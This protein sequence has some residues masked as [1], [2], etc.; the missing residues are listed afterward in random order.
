MKKAILYVRVSTDEQASHG[1]SLRDQEQRLIAYANIQGI[2]IK[3]IFREDHS[4]KN[5]NR[6]EFNKL[7]EF[8]KANKRNIDLLLFIKW[9]R[10]S[11]NATEAYEV[12]K[13]F[14]Q[15]SIEPQAIEQPLD[16]EIPE[17]KLMLALYL[18]APEVENDRR[19]M[20]TINGI[21][22]AKKEGRW[23]CGSPKGYS[24][25]RDEYNKPIIVPNDD[26]V[27]IKEA[28]EE[29]AK[30]LKP[31]DHIRQELNK[32]G[33]KCSKSNF[34]TLIRNPV[35]AGKIWMKAYKNESE[36]VVQG[37]HEAI[38]DESMFNKVQDILNGRSKKIN[39]PKVHKSKHELP[40]R[41]FLYC[42]GCQNKLT[43]SGSMGVGG[44]YF[45]YH[46][47]HCGK[48]RIPAQRANDS[49]LSVLESF[50]I[51]PEYK[52]LFIKIFKDQYLDNKQHKAKT[53]SNCQTRIAKLEERIINLEDKF[54]DNE[55]SVSDYQ[56]M[57]TRYDSQIMGL[58]AET[59]E[60]DIEKQDLNSMLNKA[61]DL[62]E[63]L[64]IVYNEAEVEDKQ[65]LISSIF[66]G[67]MYFEENRVR[68]TDLNEVVKLVCSNNKGFRG[69]KKRLML[70][71]QHQSGQVAGARF[72][73]T[74]FG[75]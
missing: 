1:Y 53:K 44:K 18:S 8:A 37:I 47:N 6:P 67:K 50:K 66:K 42:S 61:V 70:K 19:S 52:A 13:K 10:F 59:A 63:R 48:I 60:I 24:N 4:A 62:L 5:F 12:L 75:L 36:M 9:D 64:D 20:N 23:V 54:A 29:I 3:A 25:Q 43:G 17:N 32:K 35:Y 22:R 51:R 45:Y 27:H 30:G 55:I 71:N 39:R 58:R 65:K 72:E 38:I 15:L 33:F 11:R 49:L 34:A 57:S 28:F 21:R 56:K 31:Y 68:T 41:G 74:T 40:L 2:E 14:G 46:C 69:T 7:Y 73:L 16:L 26:A